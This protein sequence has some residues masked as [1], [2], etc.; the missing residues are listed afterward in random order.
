MEGAQPKEHYPGKVTLQ[1]TLWDKL[2]STPFGRNMDAQG[3][4]VLKPSAPRLTALRASHIP[5]DHYNF[6]TG[7]EVRH[8]EFSA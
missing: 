7:P 4:Y 1:P 5:M 2:E 3:N 8:P 6:P